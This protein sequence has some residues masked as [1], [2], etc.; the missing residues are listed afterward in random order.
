MATTPDLVD[1][2]QHM[3]AVCHACDYRR[4]ASADGNDGTARPGHRG[5]LGLLREAAI[6]HARDHRHRL[7]IIRTRADTFDGKVPR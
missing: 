3:E 4:R 5:P 6:A 7:V 1:R 2:I